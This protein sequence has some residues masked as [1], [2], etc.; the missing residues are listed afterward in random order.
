[1]TQQQRLK[2]HLESGKSITRLEGW[3]ELG[4]LELPARVCELR[5]SMEIKTTMRTVINRYGEKVRIA[6]WSL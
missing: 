2:A 6:V 1:M 3:D 4:I 5:E